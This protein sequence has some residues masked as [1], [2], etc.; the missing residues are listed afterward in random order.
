MTI[1]YVTSRL[2]PVAVLIFILFSGCDVISDPPIDEDARLFVGNQGNFS[3]GNGSVSA[4]HL[5]TWRVSTPIQDLESIVQ[6]LL[7]HDE[8][9]FV[10]SNTGQRL[11]A[12]DAASTQRLG[13]AAGLISPRYAAV[14]GEHVFVTN[15]F[16]D[17][18][19][20]SGGV[21]SVVN[22]QSLQRT[23]SIEVGDHPEG[24]AA[25]AGRVFVANHGFGFGSTLS[26]IDPAT[27]QVVETLDAQCEGPRYV[28][29]GA[30]DD[31]F[32]TC[33]GAT[34]YND[35]FEVIGA[36]NGTVVRWDARNRSVAAR[37][38]LDGQVM[39]SDFGQDAYFDRETNRLFVI[40]DAR[41]VRILNGTTL[42]EVGAFGPLSGDP[43]GAVTFDSE[44]ARI[45]LAR[46]AGFTTSGSVTVHRL[47]GSLE[48]TLQVGIA[49]TSLQIMR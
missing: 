24:I 44:V 11:D 49:P 13:H 5:E 33:T 36:T 23:G 46:V 21:V 27:L 38:E 28:T 43:I 4:I 6:S 8:R 40:E 48:R 20:Y 14:S 30:D 17:A 3:S 35:D 7:I 2:F 37:V 41:T 26:V 22:L 29:A 15:L 31:L 10:M 42:A 45:Y 34:M 9:L 25:Q 12:F 18:E 39:A 32:V 16:A 1:R 47:D 19:S